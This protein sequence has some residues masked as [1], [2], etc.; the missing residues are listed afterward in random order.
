VAGELEA[1][2]GDVHRLDT[3]DFASELGSDFVLA[4]RLQVAK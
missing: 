4:R 3:M 2:A 1:F